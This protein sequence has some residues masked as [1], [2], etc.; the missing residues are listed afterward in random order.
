[1]LHFHQYIEKQMYS[2][3]TRS[4]RVKLPFVER[5]LGGPVVKR[6]G[7]KDFFGGPRPPEH[8]RSGLRWTFAI[9]LQVLLP[10]QKFLYFLRS[11]DSMMSMY[12]VNESPFSLCLCATTPPE[13]TA[14]WEGAEHAGDWLVCLMLETSTV[15]FLCKLFALR[16][17][18]CVLLIELTRTDITHNTS[19]VDI[20]TFCSC[21]EFLGKLGK[22]KS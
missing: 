5:D 19:F 17:V 14:G 4:A 6:A 9:T 12:Y 13:W 3:G 21:L 10:G 2:L 20:F 11:L 22:S 16:F 1:M 18:L 8:S 7:H 15:G